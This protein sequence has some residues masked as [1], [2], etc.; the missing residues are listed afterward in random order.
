MG[1]KTHIKKLLRKKKYK[2]KVGQR[3]NIE[4]LRKSSPKEFWKHFSKC[5]GRSVCNDI[6]CDEFYEYFS[7]LENDLFSVIDQETET[8]ILMRVALSLKLRVF[9]NV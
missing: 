3:K 7:N 1:R 4:A 9:S 8:F 2:Y 6:S 5:K